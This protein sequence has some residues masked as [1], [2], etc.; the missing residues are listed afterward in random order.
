MH[1]I[2]NADDLGLCES[3]NRAI[4]EAHQRGLV[5]SASLMANGAAYQH[6]VEHVVRSNPGL[7]IGLHV[8]LTSGHSITP[9]DKLSLLVD[10]AGRFRHGFATILAMSLARPQVRDQIECEVAAQFGRLLDAGI[11]IDHVD[12]HR[13]VHMI[14]PVFSIVARLAEKHGCAA[15]RLS[16]EQLGPFGKRRSFATMLQRLINLPKA[17]L[18]RWLAFHNRPRIGSLITTDRVFGILD[19]GKMNLDSLI[20]AIRETTEGVSEIITHPSGQPTASNLTAAERRFLSSPDRLAEL[21]ALLEPQLRD[22][23][24]QHGIQLVRFCDLG[25]RQLDEQTVPGT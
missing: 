8:C 12:G 7:G 17:L 4:A 24:C 19:S 9:A 16:C 23:C 1:V 13:H 22:L 18:L 20:L 5:T 6:A 14:P 2:V 15:I 11:K 10:S 3:T 21:S 25:R